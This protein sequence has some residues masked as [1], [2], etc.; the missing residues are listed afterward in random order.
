MN[1]TRSLTS[2]GALGVALLLSARLV[3]AQTP[4]FSCPTTADIKLNVTEVDMV[5]RFKAKED[6]IHAAKLALVLEPVLDCVTGSTPT[7]CP[8]TVQDTDWDKL[9]QASGYLD[10]IAAAADSDLLDLVKIFR[11]AI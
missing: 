9:A 2:F 10:K 8:F 3:C 1:G 7:D 6:L 4:G 11:I 5:E